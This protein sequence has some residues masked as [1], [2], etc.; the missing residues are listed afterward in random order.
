MLLLLLGRV[1]VVVEVSRHRAR[2]RPYLNTSSVAARAALAAPLSLTSMLLLGLA[3]FAA[4]PNFAHSSAQPNY[5]YSCPSAMR[6]CNSLL[7]IEAR[8]DDLISRLTVPEKIEQI[9]TF[10]Y[11]NQGTE[12]FGGLTPGVSS[13]G[14]PPYNWHT[15]GLHGVRDS[16]AA[17]FYNS[18]LFPQVVGMAATGNLP[19]VEQMATAMGREFRALNNVMRRD[20]RLVNK[21]GGLSVYGP[22]INI[23]RDARWGR[24]QETVSEDPWLSGV[25]AQAF[26]RGV[27][28]GGA[29]QRNDTRQ[30]LTVAATCKHLAAYSVETNRHNSNA[31]VSSLD[32]AETYLPAFHACIA[33]EPAQVMCSYNQINGLAACL[34]DDLQNGLLRGNWSFDG[35]IVSDCDAIRDVISP[36]HALNGSAAVAAAVSAGCDI[37]CGSA[38]YDHLQTA[39]DEGLLSQQTLDTAV[40]RALRVRFRLGE[41]GESDDEVGALRSIPPQTVGAAEHLALAAQ[42]SRES[43][44]LLKNHEGTLPLDLANDRALVLDGSART[45]S[46][47]GA[48]RVLRVALIGPLGN[49]TSVMMGGKPD[50]D[51]LNVSTLWEG[52]RAIVPALVFEPGLSSVTDVSHAGFGAATVA[53]ARS[54]VVVLAIGIDS[55][56]EAEQLDRTSVG[57]TGAQD[58]LVEAV[59]AA[60]TGRPASRII[61]VLFNGGPLSVDMIA[62]SRHVHAVIEAFQPGQFGGAAVAAAI[63]GQFSPSGVMPHTVYAAADALA[64]PLTEFAMRPNRTYA[65]R[66]YR[67]S[68]SV[69]LWPFGFGLSYSSFDV[70]WKGEPV[71]TASTTALAHGGETVQF[72]V[73]VRNTGQMDAARVVQLYVARVGGARRADEPTP[74]RKSLAAMSK[75]QLRVGGEGMHTFSLRVTPGACAVCVVTFDGRTVL[76]AAEWRIS[77]GDGATDLLTGRLNVVGPEV[78]V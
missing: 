55:T 9:S 78:V 71:A 46:S 28:S 51:C 60:M 56:I 45:S 26:M 31:V 58:A 73:T 18:T 20:N 48:R 40:R 24:N 49:S 65:G 70:Q 27:Q 35:A 32:L 77:V 12:H 67:F 15:E 34:H 54:D 16:H 47:S 7:P 50:Y 3:L 22:T 59:I 11:F 8:L 30:F 74:P 6:W 2:R 57:L 14:L 38:Y 4:Q 10:T 76:R 63:A 75:L 1:L 37:D 61:A 25:Y 72:S 69:V 5:V 17:G 29:G 13:V 21:G 19:L 23:V 66:T 43:L 42:A 64:A 39:L 52:L 53:A 33:A 68:T 41:M 44:V 62:S 36:Q